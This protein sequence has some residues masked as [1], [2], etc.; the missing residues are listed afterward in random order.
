[1][2]TGS[3]ARAKKKPADGRQ[4]TLDLR[5]QLAPEVKKNGTL[6]SNDDWEKLDA[7]VTSAIGFRLVYAVVRGTYGGRVD[8]RVYGAE[9]A[10][11]LAEKSAYPHPGWVPFSM[12]DLMRIGIAT[13]SGVNKAVAELREIGLETQRMDGQTWYRLAPEKLR[14]AARATVRRVSPKA[15]ETNIPT[16][17]PS[18]SEIE[19]PS[20]INNLPQCELSQTAEL[21]SFTQSLADQPERTFSPQ[22]IVVKPGEQS[23]PLPLWAAIDTIRLRNPNSFDLVTTL[24]I[25]GRI[26]D[27]TPTPAPAA[28]A[29]PKAPS[30]NEDALSYEQLKER[31][32]RLFRKKIGEVLPKE[33]GAQIHNLIPTGRAWREF[34]EPQ[35][36]ENA[37]RVRKWPFLVLLAKKAS[38]AYL[39]ELADE[40]AGNTPSPAAVHKTAADLREERKWAEVEKIHRKGMTSHGPE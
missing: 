5:F 21:G 27:V 22:T 33:F 6:F 19:L 32:N 25:T 20:E 28:A 26:L 39:E 14:A 13:E 29:P 38:E 34:F 12:A 35:L 37:H 15:E 24:S 1:M 17:A 31:L 30:Q 8:P 10:A 7:A 16:D 9:A 36:T 18:T 11:Y 3:A 4:Q 23:P 2:S 40:R